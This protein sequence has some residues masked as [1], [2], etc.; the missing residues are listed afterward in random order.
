M[1]CIAQ[2]SLI[3]S[4]TLHTTAAERESF[5]LGLVVMHAAAHLVGKQWHVVQN[6]SNMSMHA[7]VSG[8]AIYSGTSKPRNYGRMDATLTNN[9]VRQSVQQHALTHAAWGP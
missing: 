6:V 1:L 9:A 8:A 2:L 4:N 3:G 7:E 5:G